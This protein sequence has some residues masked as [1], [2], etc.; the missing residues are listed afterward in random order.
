VHDRVDRLR[1]PD[2]RDFI[3]ENNDVT[4]KMGMCLQ[5]IVNL[6]DN[7]D[8]DGDC[9]GGTINVP[10]FQKVFEEWVPRG[11]IDVS[12][13]GVGSMQYKF[14]RRG[15]HLLIVRSQLGWQKRSASTRWDG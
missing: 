4:S 8:E 1:Y 14:G 13:R 6:Q 5:G 7:T 3:R 10:G 15:P 11:G 12:Q 9:G 2:T